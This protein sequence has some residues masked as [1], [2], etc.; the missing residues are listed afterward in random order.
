MEGKV[1][2]CGESSRDRCASW[3]GCPFKSKK[4][5]ISDVLIQRALKEILLEL[6]GRQTIEDTLNNSLRPNCYPPQD[7][8]VK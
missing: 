2:F 7:L 6:N 3:T 5:Q 8:F 4:D 1:S